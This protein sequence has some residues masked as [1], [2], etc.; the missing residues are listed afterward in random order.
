MR[1]NYTPR[2]HS[3]IVLFGCRDASSAE[4]YIT[5]FD[6]MA[7]TLTIAKYTEENHVPE[8]QMWLEFSKKDL[9]VVTS[10]VSVYQHLSS[11]YIY[12]FS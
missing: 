10:N 3:L 7:P 4:K 2:V 1:A 6:K 12:F 9:V 8:P 5:I 11:S